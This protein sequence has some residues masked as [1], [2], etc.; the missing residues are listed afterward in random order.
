[1][2]LKTD[3]LNRTAFE[4]TT[5]GVDIEKLLESWVDATLAL[6]ASD[7]RLEVFEERKAY[8]IE[9]IDV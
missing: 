7:A 9:N 3:L 1:M 6:D 8:L 2:Q 5:D 4:R